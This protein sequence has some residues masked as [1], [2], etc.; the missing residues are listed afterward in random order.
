MKKTIVSFIILLLLFSVCSCGWSK[1]HTAVLEVNNLQLGNDVFKH[2]YDIGAEPVISKDDQKKG[3]EKAIAFCNVKYLLEYKET[4]TY[5]LGDVC[6][7]EY[8]VVDNNN[9]GKVLILPDG[10]IYAMLLSSIGQIDI[11]STA[12]A[13]TVRQ[14]VELYLEKELDFGSFKYCN[15]TCSL[16]DVSD[17]FG[18]YSFVWYNTIGDIETDQT[19][20]LC[21]KQNGEINALWMKFRSKNSFEGVSA[22]ISI[23]DYLDKIKDKVDSIYGDDLI[24]SKV[25]SSVL[26]HYDGRIYIDCVIAVSIEEYSETCRLLIPVEP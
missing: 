1:T 13:L 14:A 20:N 16:P 11:E 23:D 21:V 24:E 19:L 18:L 25:V 6:V 7:D 17:G 4:I 10:E 3:V 8:V 5:V 22:S 26:T 9:Q 15:V 12:D 2:T